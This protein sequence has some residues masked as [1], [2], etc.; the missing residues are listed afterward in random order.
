MPLQLEHQLAELNGYNREYR[1]LT[2]SRAGE[3]AADSLM[4]TLPSR[5]RIPAEARPGLEQIDTQY[6][7][8]DALAIYHQKQSDR[9]FKFF[10]ATTFAMGLAYLPYEKFIEVR[11]LLIAYLLVLLLAVGLYQLPQAPL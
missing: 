8:A 11:V 3:G 4:R 9:L 7:K 2:G 5:L 10:S 6:G 1:Q